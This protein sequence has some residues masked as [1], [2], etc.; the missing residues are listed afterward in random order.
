MLNLGSRFDEL[1][2]WL[3]WLF[4]MWDQ[5]RPVVLLEIPNST[6][7]TKDEGYTVGLE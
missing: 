2:G 4:D 3:I 6:T 7:E 1:V 5:P